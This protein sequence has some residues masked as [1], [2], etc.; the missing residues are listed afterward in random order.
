MR[1]RR[2]TVA[3]P[4][5]DTFAMR[6][7]RSKAL[8]LGIMML[9]I[10]GAIGFLAWEAL[11]PAWQSPGDD[12]ALLQA[13]PTWVRVPFFVLIGGVV[14]LPGLM[15][16]WAGLTKRII[17]QADANH[18]SSRTIFGHRRT[19]PWHAIGSA[20]YWRKEN[21]IALSPIG[22][23]GIA[24]EIWDRKSVLIDVGMLDHTVA[25]VERMVRHF[26]PDLTIVHGDSRDG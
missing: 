13:L 19:L 1:G 25:D 16:V 10:G 22:H 23:G 20:Q 24:E 8:G 17:V 14:L 6:H 21:Q 7:R 3:A 4:D 18:I 5:G 9:A 12:G 15:M 11:D 26:R 2:L